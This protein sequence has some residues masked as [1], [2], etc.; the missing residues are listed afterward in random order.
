MQSD[1]DLAEKN[2]ISFNSMVQ[3][4]LMGKKTEI[5]IISGA[6]VKEGEQDGV[7]VPFN[8]TMTLIVKALE[9]AIKK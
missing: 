4:F 5:D 1:Y 9:H 7:F 2:A 3:D 6:I 8:E